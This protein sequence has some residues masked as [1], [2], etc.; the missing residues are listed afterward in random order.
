MI[1]KIPGWD[2]QAYDD[3]NIRING[4][5]LTQSEFKELQSRKRSKNQEDERNFR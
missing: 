5:L 3:G 4:T 2:I 1:V